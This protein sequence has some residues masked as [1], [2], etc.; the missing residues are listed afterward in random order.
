M[1]SPHQFRRFGDEQA[2][3]CG[4]SEWLVRY[5]D[6]TLNLSQGNIK[7]QCPQCNEKFVTKFYMNSKFK[8]VG[9]EK[10]AKKHYDFFNAN[11]EIISAEKD[12]SFLELLEDE[13]ILGS[14]RLADNH[15][16]RFL[17]TRRKIL[18][19]KTLKRLGLIDPLV[20]VTNE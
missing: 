12:S 5:Y 3:L 13:F 16:C 6:F 11:I 14:Y 19:K 18:R 9:S 4:K 2:I 7:L 10:E 8:I 17:D 1:L 20:L 15:V